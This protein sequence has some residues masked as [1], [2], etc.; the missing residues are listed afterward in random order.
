MSSQDTAPNTFVWNELATSRPDLCRDFYGAVFGWTTEE[1]DLGDFG[2]Y[3]VWMLDGHGIGGMLHMDDADGEQPIS[4]WT[5]YIAVE[6][7]EETAKA[8]LDS[9]G[10]IKLP[11]TYVPELGRIAI[12]A[13][14]A[15]AVIAVINPQIPED[16]DAGPEQQAEEA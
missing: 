5:S 11:P 15:G 13:D 7:V 3:S 8:V 16:L 12:I 2:T 14:P 4:F 10:T 1:V 6:D 9:G